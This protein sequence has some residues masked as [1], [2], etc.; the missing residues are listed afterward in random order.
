LGNAI[1]LPKPAGAS[2]SERR[3][4][5][6]IRPEDLVACRPEEAWFSGQLAVAERLGSQTYGY[7]EI[8][9]SSMLT[10]EFPRDAEIAVGQTIH[11]K[12]DTARIHLFSEEN[13]KRLN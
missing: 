3:L 5:L 11:V 8:G 13:G 6:G 2:I 4:V 7:L 12:G 9:H 1:A 10:V